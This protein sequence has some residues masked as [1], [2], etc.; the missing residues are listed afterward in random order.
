MNPSSKGEIQALLTAWGLS[1]S[2]I[3]TLADRPDLVADLQRAR[4]LPPLPADYRPDV[5]EFLYEDIPCIR[6][7][8]GCWIDLPQNPDRSFSP[9]FWEIA[10]DGEIALFAVGSEYAID[11]LGTWGDRAAALGL[12]SQAS[13]WAVQ[14]PTSS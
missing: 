10:L 3:A 9:K 7:E 12:L 4:S 14:S 5:V 2:A 6:L 13:A 1:E 11:R 8:G